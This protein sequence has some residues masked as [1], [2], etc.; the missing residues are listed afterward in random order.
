MQPNFPI[1]LTVTFFAATLYTFVMFGKACK[2]NKKAMYLLIVWIGLQGTFGLFSFYLDTSSVP[3]RI[4]LLVLPALLFILYLFNNKKGRDFIDKLNLETLTL[5]HVV[6]IPIEFCLF[7]LCLAG[8]IPELM[9]FEGRNFDII[10]GITAPLVYFL[11]FMRKKLSQ[12]ALLAWNIIM[13]LLLINIVVNALLSAPLPIQQFA[14]DQP[15]VGI[16]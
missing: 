3:P 15:N 7:W 6:R 2:W 4:L 9:T 16:L 1:Y 11:Y 5:I 10:A 13:L 8:T 14:F 12:R